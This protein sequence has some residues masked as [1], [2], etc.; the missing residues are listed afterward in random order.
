MN[1]QAPVQ[2]AITE[3]ISRDVRE[4]ESQASAAQPLNRR[5]LLKLGSGL[6]LGLAFYL[7]APGQGAKAAASAKEFSPNAFLRIFPDG[8]ILIYAK[9]PEVGQGVKTSLPMIVAEELDAA[10][11]DVVVEQ[12]IID[13]QLY[14]RQAAGGSTSIPVNWDPLRR[15]GAAARSMLVSAAAKQWGVKDSECATADSAVLHAASNRRLSYG[16]LS[17]KAASLPVPDPKSLTL[18]SRDQF[19]LLGTR[20]GGVDNPQVVSGA[21]LFGIDQVLPGMAY[22]VFEKCPA[23]GGK[24]VSANLDHIKSLPGVK[25]AFVLEG[26]GVVQDLMPGVAI[27]ADSTWAAFKAKLALQVVWD[28]SAASKDSW[29]AINVKARELA[30][31]NGAQD[32]VKKGDVDKAFAGAAKKLEAFYSY[33]F[34]PHAPMEPQNCTAW[35]K[36]DHIELWAPTQ[37]PQ[38]GQQQVAGVLKLAEDKVTVHQT[39]AGGGFGRRLVNDFMCEAAAISQRIN[40]PV[41]LQW[42]REDDTRHDFYRVGGFHSLT[43][44]LDASGKLIGLRDH[45]ITFSADGKTPVIGGNITAEEFP[46]PLIENA[47]LT[48]TMLPLGTPCGAWRAPRSNSVAFAVQ[49]F[50][51]E[52]ATAAGRDHLEFL[53]EIMGEPRWLAP[54]TPGALNTGRASGVIKLAAEKAGWGRAMPP[55]RGLGLAF[56]FSHAGHIAEVAEVSVDA[57]MN[58]RVHKVTVAAD[59]GPIVNLSGAENQVQG[60]VVDGLSTMMNLELSIEHGR[61]QEGN[62]HDYPILRMAEA[63]EVDVHFIQSDFPPT[64]VGEPGLPPL[65]PAVANAV[66]AASGQRVRALPMMKRGL[67][68]TNVA[69]AN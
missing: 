65:A 53:L 15:A 13:A 48:Q 20:V 50:I 18:K 5:S 62:F 31:Q 49:S 29:S 33:P 1:A 58:V 21:P 45:F 38:R 63:P 4:F 66:F 14:G 26:N 69:S 17:V 40:G 12:S 46:M 52:L 19:K 2:R 56:Y 34:L 68:R 37:T 8:K 22:A 57:T 25:D 3:Q 27:V 28:E 35:F 39:R 47:H 10:W 24:V 60:S 16:E 59:I 54:G 44:A 6:G 7:G 41:K 51:H 36:G 11:A 55:G 61:I 67:K 32:I 23:T 9:N 42:T 30:T 64:G 43:G